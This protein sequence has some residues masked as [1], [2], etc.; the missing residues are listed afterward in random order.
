[1]SAELAV[2]YAALILEDDNVEITVGKNE[3]NESTFSEINR[4]DIF[5]FR[6]ISSRLSFLPLVLRLNPSGSLSMPRPL[7][8]KTSRLSC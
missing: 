5:H 1:M 7:L 4:F 6:L 2:V 8:V 3:R